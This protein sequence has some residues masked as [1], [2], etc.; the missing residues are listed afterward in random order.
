MPQMAKMEE[1][2]DEVFVQDIKEG[3]SQGLSD[4]I[5]AVLRDAAEEALRN[6]SAIQDRRIRD[7]FHLCSASIIYSERPPLDQP[8]NLEI[9]EIL[10][11]EMV[12]GSDG[13]EG[14]LIAKR[15]DR[16]ARAYEYLWLACSV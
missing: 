5:V 6:L 9:Q 3:Q 16:R 15:Q 2:I 4:E 12:Q 13:G 1:F 8:S 11:Q 14:H 7:L 10:D